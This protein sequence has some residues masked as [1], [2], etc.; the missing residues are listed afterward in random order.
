MTQYYN[1]LPATPP[2]KPIPTVSQYD[3]VAPTVPLKMVPCPPREQ[4]HGDVLFMPNKL[5]S[6]IPPRNTL[7]TTIQDKMAAVTSEKL[8]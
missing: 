6:P 2:C 7:R 4:M 3:N 1:V 5:S 8:Y